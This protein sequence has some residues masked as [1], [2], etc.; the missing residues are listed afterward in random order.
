MAFTVI[1]NSEIEAGDPVTQPLQQKIKD[2]FDDHEARILANA[3][4]AAALQ[5]ILFDVGG[6]YASIGVKSDLLVYRAIFD[7]KITAARL[8]IWTA[9]TSGSTEVDV[10]L[11]D[12]TPSTIFST[13]PSVAF[14]AG[15][16]AVSSNAI[17]IT[18]PLNVLT[19]EFLILDQ[20]AVQ[21][22]GD[23]YS[24]ALEIEPI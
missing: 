7:F 4:S 9:G 11:D 20:T 6:K 3:A 5:P 2:N 23:G 8:T 24:L 12:G 22:K 18:S 14:S 13:R 21:T 17:F 15:D 19:G 1:N 10:R 16:L